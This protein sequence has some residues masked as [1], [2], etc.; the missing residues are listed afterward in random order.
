MCK[1]RTQYYYSVLP[2]A[3]LCSLIDY[4]Q[5]RSTAV[6]TSPSVYL[7]S[8]YLASDCPLEISPKEIVNLAELCY[9]EHCSSGAQQGWEVIPRKPHKVHCDVVHNPISHIFR[10][11]PEAVVSFLPLTYPLTGSGFYGPFVS[12]EILIF[13]SFSYCKIPC[14]CRAS[15]KQTF[16]LLF[17]I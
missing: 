9:K 12:L 11:Y 3:M 8:F 6:F 14:D 13:L 5:D 4:F 10:T 7:P 17:P 16:L 2:S 15:P 1:D